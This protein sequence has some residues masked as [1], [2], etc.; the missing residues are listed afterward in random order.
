[1][2]KNKTNFS[3]DYV[4]LDV[5]AGFV[6]LVHWPHLNR[7]CCYFYFDDYDDD[8]AHVGDD[9][10]VHVDDDDAHV[11]GDDAQQLQTLYC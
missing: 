9:D 3:D 11:D 5:N 1:M 4:L 6:P 2:K 7:L 8:D 10:N